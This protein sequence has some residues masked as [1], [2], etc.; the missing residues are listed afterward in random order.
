MLG[1]I[2]G[3]LTENDLLAW[4]KTGLTR[5]DA[6]LEG[7]FRSIETSYQQRLEEVALV[8]AGLTD[9]RAQTEELASDAPR[10]STTDLAFPKEA[11]RKRSNLAENILL[12]LRM[13]RF[14]APMVS[15]RLVSCRAGWRAPRSLR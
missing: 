3:L 8:A 5:K 6:L 14:E 15:Q 10:D 12:K 13:W 2:A 11:V 7:D 4:A 9:I 1:E